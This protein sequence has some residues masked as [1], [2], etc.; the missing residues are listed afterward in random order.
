MFRDQQAAIF[1]IGSLVVA[2]AMAVYF[3]FAGLYL[4]QGAEVKPENVGPVM[5]IGQWVEIFFLLS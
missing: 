2:M 1:F 3:A 4:E 5:T